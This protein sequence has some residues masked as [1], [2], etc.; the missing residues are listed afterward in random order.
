MDD[1]RAMNGVAM[2]KVIGCRQ[3]WGHETRV[4]CARRRSLGRVLE[5]VLEGKH[6][7]LCGRRAVIFRI[8]FIDRAHLRVVLTVCGLNSRTLSSIYRISDEY[9]SRIYTKVFPGKRDTD[10]L[11]P[12]LFLSDRSSDTRRFSLFP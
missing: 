7:L 5:R 6:R 11:F 12:I 3:G 10:A 1:M 2:K 9:N 4:G 8:S